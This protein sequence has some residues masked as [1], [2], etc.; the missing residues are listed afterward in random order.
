[1]IWVGMTASAL[2]LASG[3]HAANTKLAI[4]LLSGAMGFNIF[5]TVTWWATCI[6]LTRNFSGSLSAMMN[7]W[8]NIGGWISPIL[9]AYIATRWGWTQALDF[10]ALITLAAPFLWIFVNADEDLEAHV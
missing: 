9:T 7:T 10:A 5:A 1:M 4:L 6:D 3:A 8:G 2:L